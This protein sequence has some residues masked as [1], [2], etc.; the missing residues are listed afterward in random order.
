MQAAWGD[1]VDTRGLKTID[2]LLGDAVQ[3][4]PEEDAYYTECVVCF[5][6]DYIFYAPP[7]YAP[8]A[9]PA[10]CV[11]QSGITFGCFSEVTKIGPATIVTWSE[12][13]RAIPDVRFVLNNRLLADTARQ[14][15][16]V[17]LFRDCGIGSDRVI[18]RTGGM[19]AAFLGQ[20]AEVDVVLD[21]APYSGGLT[22]CEALLMGVPALTVPG[23]RFL[24]STVCDLPRFADTSYGSLRQEWAL[25]C[26]SRDSGG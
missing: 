16:I 6:P 13:L 3:N 1:Y 15:H 11:T 21:T 20:Y 26:E 5:V 18:F 24:S 25:L 7:D 19:H 4:P 10:P 14:Q 9:S 8:T 22:T 12:V 23:N 2:I 17:G